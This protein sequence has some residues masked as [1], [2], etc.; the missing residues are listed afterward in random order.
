MKSKREL[1]QDIRDSE[2]RERLLRGGRWAQ[3][4]DAQLKREWKDHFAI[5][6]TEMDQGHAIID[7]EERAQRV[8]VLRELEEEMKRRKLPIDPRATDA[9]EKSQSLPPEEMRRLRAQ[10]YGR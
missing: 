9:F 10:V 8:A 3:F 1:E 5:Y 2:L 6:L 7:S 4:S